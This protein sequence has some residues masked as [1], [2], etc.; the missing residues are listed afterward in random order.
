MKVFTPIVEKCAATGLIA[1]FGVVV[2]ALTTGGC[3]KI[4][5]VPK[6]IEAKLSEN[7]FG[8]DEM[9]ITVRNVGTSGKVFIR[10]K[11]VTDG[12]AVWSTTAYFDSGE[13]RVVVVKLEGYQTGKLLTQVV[14]EGL[15]E[16][17]D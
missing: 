5:P 13:Q 9:R 17:L 3:T 6:V 10:V 16:G 7:L 15:K 4:I 14:A 11:Q 1:V 8:P 12:N 2:L